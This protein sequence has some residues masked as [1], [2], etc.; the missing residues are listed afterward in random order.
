[1]N[2]S[3]YK[4]NKISVD[5]SIGIDEVGRGPL[6]GPVVAAS[7]WI[8]QTS[9]IK[10]SDS[11]LVVRDS[12]KMSPFQRKK[13]VDWMKSQSPKDIKYSI[14]SATV[15]E[16]DNLNILNASLLAMERSHN[17][18]DKSTKYILVD[19]NKAPHIKNADILTIIKGDTQVLSIALA[20]IIAKEYR[21]NLMQQLSMEYPNYGWKTNV[22]YGSAKHIEAISKFGITQHHRKTFM[23]LKKQLD[24]EKKIKMFFC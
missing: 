24:L 14:A 19:G 4:E 2:L 23:P 3:W 15:E 17:S 8:S 21:D 18:L 20:S 5:D 7:V 6:A 9:A 13:I 22:G 16:I 12:K 1:M 11:D 10:L